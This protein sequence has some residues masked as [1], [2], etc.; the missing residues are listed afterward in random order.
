M[1][2]GEGEK[3]D[4]GEGTITHRHAQPLCRFF[5][6]GKHCNFGKKC[7]FLHVRGD[8][9]AEKKA[10]MTPCQSEDTPLHSDGLGGN[11]E[12]RPPLN[13]NNKAASEAGRRICRYFMSGHCTMEDR[14]RFLHPQQ[15]ITVD[16]HVAPKNPTRPTQK[17][18]PVPHPG[19]LQEVKLCDMT[20]DVAKQLRDTE[21]KQ[22]K[23][24]FPKDQLIIQERD[25]GKVT[26]Y[27]AS[28]E[29]TDPDWVNMFFFSV[30]AN[31][32]ASAVLMSKSLLKAD[33][34]RV[35]LA[36]LFRE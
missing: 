34:H 17:M 10:I 21:I 13:N 15:Y 23:K 19:I 14:C 16:D 35:R 33:Q 24:R 30:L 7:K 25:D 3:T 26:Y 2:P 22:L 27:R 11:E 9:R 20:E 36:L 32:R 5:S 29:A 1:E 8:S 18:A 6:Q 28:V 12:Q 31:L 4:V